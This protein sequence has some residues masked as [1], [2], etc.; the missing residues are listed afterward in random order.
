MAAQVQVLSILERFSSPRP[1]PAAL[2]EPCQALVCCIICIARSSPDF[3]FVCYPSIPRRGAHRQ[4]AGA[5]WYTSPDLKLAC[6]Q[7]S[8][9]HPTSSASALVSGAQLPNFPCTLRL[10]AHCLK[11]FL[12]CGS[13]EFPLLCFSDVTRITLGYA[14]A[15]LTGPALPVVRVPRFVPGAPL[16]ERRPDA[17]QPC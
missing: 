3:L 6:C 15:R 5:S 7:V 12:L 9:P 1:R 16:P 11:T 14:G 17:T 13:T 10:P 8:H 2:A 4:A